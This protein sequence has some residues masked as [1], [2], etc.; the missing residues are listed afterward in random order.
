MATERESLKV[1]NP[2]TRG[3][4]FEYRVGHFFERWGY[5]WDRSGS[6]LG[7]DLKILKN[8]KLRYLVSCKKTSKPRP[9]YLTRHEVKRL[10]IEASR[11][12]AEG[13]VCFGFHRTPIYVIPVKEVDKI[14]STRLYYKI[15]P[16]DGILL[17]EFLE[18]RLEVNI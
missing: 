2:K 6:S 18:D 17:S 3:V 12:G 14:E 1:T 16:G 13:L 7:I 11:R 5:S 10:S 8:G 4:M 9:I 15:K